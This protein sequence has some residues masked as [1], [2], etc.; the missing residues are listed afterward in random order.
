MGPLG[1]FS[2]GLAA[3]PAAPSIICR[4]QPEESVY[5][6]GCHKPI[7]NERFSNLIATWMI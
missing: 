6:S 7:L 4:K 1:H 3:K 2:V 5:R